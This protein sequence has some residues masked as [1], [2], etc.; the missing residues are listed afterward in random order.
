[1]S[2]L[3]FKDCVERKRELYLCQIVPLVYSYNTLI[4]LDEEDIEYFKKKYYPKLN[5]ELAKEL[6]KVIK[7]Y[8]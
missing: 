5:D 1:M 3:D 8:N 6:E 4:Q 2:V 7:K